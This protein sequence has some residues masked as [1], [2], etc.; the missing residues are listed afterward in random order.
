MKLRLQGL[1]DH[2]GIRRITHALL[3]VDIG[4]RINFDLDAQ[5]V[6]IE[7]RYTLDDAKAAIARGGYQVASVVD[8]TLVDAVSRPSRREVL[9]F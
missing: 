5:L 3:Q 6:R 9:A 2:D 8:S 4:G 1:Q 7:G